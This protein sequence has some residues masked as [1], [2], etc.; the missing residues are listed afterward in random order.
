MLSCGPLSDLASHS[1]ECMQKGMHAH[2]G[3]EGTI[4][5]GPE[6]EEEDGAYHGRHVR[7]IGCAVLGV[8]GSSLYGC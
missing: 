6:D 4:E 1:S 7:H 3:G 5:A 2:P 8:A